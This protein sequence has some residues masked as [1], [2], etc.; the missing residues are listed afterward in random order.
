MHLARSLAILSAVLTLAAVSARGQ[1][2]AAARVLADYARL[3]QL[4]P[5]LEG[6]AA[7]RGVLEYVE[8]RLRELGIA[9]RRLDFRE[10]DQNHSFSGCLVASLAG[11]RRDR[12]LLVVPLNHPVEASRD[13][14]GSINVALALGLLTAVGK[15]RPAL[16][17]EVLFLG[18]E[19][20]GGAEY[21]MGSRLFLRDFTP[22]ERAMAMYLN[23]RSVPSR[24]HVRAG[25]RG[26]E[27][28]FWLIDR[29]TRALNAAG[30]FF[31]VRGNET[32]IFRIGLTDAPTV[33]EP[34]L[35]AGYPAVVLEGEYGGLPAG[36]EEAWVASFLAFLEGFGDS[37]RG[38]IP[39]T[40]DR[41]YL[42]FQIRSFYFRVSEQLY[43]V[44]LIGVLAAALLYSLVF[45]PRLRRYLRLLGRDFWVLPL[46]FLFIFLLLFLA[47]WALEGLLRLRN[48]AD[49]WAHLPLPF[50]AFKLAVPL[51]VFFSLLPLLRRLRVPLRGSFYSAAALLFLLADIAVLAAVNIS[52][53]YYFLWAFACALLF[54]AVTSRV[55]KL[56]FF[57][58]SPYWILKAVLELFSLPVLRFCQVVLLS[59]L[60]GNLLLAGV[61]LP[62]ILM[63][64][65]LRLVLPLFRISSRRTR[66]VVSAALFAVVLSGL[67]GFFLFY[68]PYGPGRPQPVRAEYLVDRVSGE[69]RVELA[70]PAPLRG[71]YLRDPGG[72][73]VVD[74]RARFASRP[75]PRIEDL[76]AP[77]VTA[78]GFLDRKNVN[79]ALQPLGSPVRIR[80]T[81]SAPEEFVLYD[82]NFPYQREPDGRR[83]TLLIGVNPPLPL[84]VQLTLPQAR[85]FVLGL[86]LEYG[87]PPAG[88]EAFGDQAEVRSRLTY[89]M[90]LELKT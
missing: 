28:P 77:R 33:I 24:L 57:L 65:R 72:L 74:T 82:A 47:S 5:R 64:I 56:L 59:K 21:P 35:D 45:T 38:G 13:R 19:F 18:A 16:S 85:S 80:L 31:L 17:L 14:D 62:F 55:L 3:Q 7:E 68:S 40:W 2:S 66:Q 48:S 32:Q 53:T 71:L 30:L 75:L 73:R 37:F 46:Y 15:T 88:F 63:Y 90:S 79:L 86:E 67:S 89:R 27:S 10:S 78:V 61:L 23:L 8:A 25:G 81:V 11:E 60:W 6:S 22:S 51:L 41:H 76:V 50:L 87:E 20:G 83:Y 69:A 58:A 70:S 1:Q 49:L 36:G 84:S 42:F 9:S 44:L 4:Y 26:I 54:S 39:E 43:V 12:L 34:F 29:T 52:F